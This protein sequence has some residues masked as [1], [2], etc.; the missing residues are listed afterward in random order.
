MGR[1]HVVKFAVTKS[2]RER[3]EQQA[4]S[5]GYVTVAS[6]LRDLALQKNEFLE[7]KIIETNQHV[8]KLME[9]FQNGSSPT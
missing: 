5:L 3:I 9:A 2:Q 7:S 8:K 4:H 1:N 6:Y